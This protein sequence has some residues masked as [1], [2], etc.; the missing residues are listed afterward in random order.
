MAQYFISDAV[1]LLFEV[2]VVGLPYE[3]AFADVTSDSTRERIGIISQDLISQFN[4]GTF[5][6]ELTS[7]EIF[8]LR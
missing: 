1:R 2:E 8:A 6:F 5:Q 4:D 3:A 7:V